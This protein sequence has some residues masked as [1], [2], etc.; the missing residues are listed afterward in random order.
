MFDAIVAPYGIDGTIRSNIGF[1][2][3]TDKQTEKVGAYTITALKAEHAPHLNSLNYIIS[4]GTVNVLYLIDSGYPAKANLDYLNSKNYVF[5]CVVMDATMGY[6]PIGEYV[7][8]MGFEENKMLKTE[9]ISRGLATE[10]TKFVATHFTHNKAETHDKI[11]QI[12][13]GTGFIVA[14]DG[15]EINVS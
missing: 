3:M 10:K 7:Y 6:A 8:H 15:I 9:L 14:Y 4:D 12:Y 1:V 5:D 13:D 11:E 2:E